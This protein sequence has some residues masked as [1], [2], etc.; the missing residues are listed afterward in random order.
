[1][2]FFWAVSP[3]TTNFVVVA[4]AIV[5]GLVLDRANVNQ[6]L[7]TQRLQVLEDSYELQAALEHEISEKLWLTEGLASVITVS[8][9]LG[10]DEYA[11]SAAILVENSD[12]V[13]NVAASPDM[14]IEFIY[15][16]EGNEATLG[17]DLTQQGQLV[18][19]LQQAIDTG[20]T[21]FTGPVELLQGMQGFITRAAVYIEGAEGAEPELWGIVSLVM[22]AGVLFE[23]VGLG[24]PGL[25]NAYAIHDGDGLLLAGDASIMEL[26]PVATS[27]SAPGV[28]WELLAA[29][30]DGWSLSPPNRMET[31]L[32][33][34][35]IT[36]GLL[37]VFRVLQ[38]A[39]D[40]KDVA[41]TQ[42]AEA[43][44]S[45]S[46]GFALY[47]PDGNLTMCN[48]TYRD[49][50]PRAA[51]IMQPGVSFEQILRRGIETGHFPH[52][53][54]REAEWITERVAA[55]RN[56]TEPVEF[57]MP[58]G[59]WL[60][61][62]ERKTASDH[63]AGILVDVTQLKDAVVRS[64][65][66]SAAKTDFLN[67]VSHELRTPLSV[68][69]GYNSFMKNLSALPSYRWL[70]GEIKTDDLHDRLETFAKDI[71]K[72]SDQIDTSGKQL[73]ALIASVLDIAAIEEGTL[74]LHPENLSLEQT[75]AETVSQLQVVAQG[76]GLDLILDASESN[77]WADPVRL[78][79]IL[80]NII[81]NALKFTE[82]GSVTVRSKRDHA[83]T[84]IIVTDTGPGIEPVVLASIFDR[85]KQA[86]ASSSRKHGGI[87]L[88]LS[89]AKE[90]TELHKGT[91]QVDSHVG[92]G[93]TFK[94]TLP[95]HEPE[96]N[97]HK[98]QDVASQLPSQC[99]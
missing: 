87:G 74:Q 32:V 77:V 47:D 1:M 85:F 64:E 37:V 48:Q 84:H 42:L 71:K 57:K 59:R 41:E 9:D 86:D 21:I 81:G 4:M 91:I 2:R 18:S 58:D 10:Q 99:A 88:G 29:P 94:V 61:V 70:Q 93:T 38:W 55:H 35:L 52:A 46:D 66:A 75:L 24:A 28:N 96:Q 62:E 17:V 69:L 49:M 72:F 34:L 92:E 16:I 45:L 44:E 25:E 56:P 5:V 82:S 73:M 33:L 89:I 20:E 11:R 67:T 40:R 12:N 31:W 54:G 15:P 7:S 13:I 65:A 98:K 83:G 36:L 80:L 97:G 53:E 27:V 63:V 79:Q 8:P 51:D 90:L 76:K 43:V 14:V 68:I 6:H 3:Y 39:L 30:R 23:T 78:R 95:S 26:A 22:D 50:F 60:R 19:G